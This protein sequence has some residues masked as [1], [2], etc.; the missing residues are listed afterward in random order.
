MDQLNTK[1]GNFRVLLIGIGDNTEAEKE[2]FCNKFSNQYGIS[3]QKIRNIID[4]CPVVLKKN[5]TFKKAEIL[6]KKLTSFGGK[7]SIQERKGD[8]PIHLE[9][10][11][12]S[13][14]QV[15]LESTYLKRTS[16]GIW[17]LIGRVKNISQ[18]DLN[19]IWIMVQIFDDLQDLITFEEVPIP[20]NPL[21][22]GEASPF[23]IIFDKEIPIVRVSI[24]FKNSSGS[25]LAAKDQRKEWREVELEDQDIEDVGAESISVE[26]Y[27]GGLENI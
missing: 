24:A 13:S 12:L 17:N 8:I 3:E 1:A 21:P 11:R 4:R 7:V 9:F 25:P 19:D 10:Q 23:K 2:S 5:L 20:V 27:P 26:F 14:P 6:A 15:S 18:E 22:Q 16:S